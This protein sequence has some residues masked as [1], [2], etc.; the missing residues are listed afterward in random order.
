M[1][2]FQTYSELHQFITA[3]AKSVQQ[4]ESSLNFPGVMMGGTTTV[5]A[6]TTTV[7][8]SMTT[9]M[10]VS[11]ATTEAGA[12]PASGSTSSGYT[13][14][15]DQVQGVDELDTVKTDGTYLYVAS[16]QTVAIIQTQPASSTSILST[17]RLPTSEILGI[18]IAP[19][20]L[21]V[22]AQSNLNSSVDVRLYDLTNPRAPTLINSIGVS[23]NYVAAR[24]S[25]GYLYEI[26]QQPSF[27]SNGNGNV[28]AQNPTVVEQGVSSVLSPGS[29]YYTPNKS[30]VSVYTMVM[31]M[32]MTTGAQ[33][34]VAVLTGSASTVYASATNIY[35]VYPNYPSYYADGIGGDIFGGQGSGQPQ[36]STVFRVAYS[37]GQIAVKIDRHRKVAVTV[38]DNGGLSC[39]VYRNSALGDGIEP[40]KQA[41]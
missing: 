29:T 24:I 38:T 2:S 11:S 6:G 37:D 33:T 28:T 21:A 26:V 32:S 7:Q 4:Y 20:R 41:K 13:T 1:S 25:Q 12:V 3:N 14:T 34:S 17:I 30:Q 35:V 23:G 15:N 18:A 16:S 8:G 31:S 40:Q 19:Q 5:F 27:V 39:S 9:T 22:V 36:N 10:T